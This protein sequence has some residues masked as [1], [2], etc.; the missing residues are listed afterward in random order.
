MAAYALARKGYLALQG[1]PDPSLATDLAKAAGESVGVESPHLLALSYALQARGLALGGQRDPCLARLDAAAEALAQSTTD[2]SPPAWPRQPWYFSSEHLHSHIGA[3]YPHIGRSPEAVDLIRGRL[4]GLPD[5]YRIERGRQLSQLAV[6]H[7]YN[8]DPATAAETGLEAFD[9][10]V[11]TG[12]SALCEDLHRL[13]T[14]LA[15]FDVAA[16]HRFKEALAAS[17][18]SSVPPYRH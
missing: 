8:D 3:C 2:S 4:A 17:G 15:R 14:R 18:G 12:S 16:V 9:I 7:A 5:E 1:D 6:A 13:A 10:A 11:E